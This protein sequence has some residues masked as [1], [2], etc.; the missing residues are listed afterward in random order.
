MISR[1]LCRR[2]YPVLGLLLLL[3]TSTSVSQPSP[4][5][6]ERLRES[7]QPTPEQ[8]RA[9][10]QKLEQELYRVES[11]FDAYDSAVAEVSADIGNRLAERGFYAEALV[12]YRRSLHVLRINEGLDSTRQIPILESIVRTYFKLGEY[13]ETLGYLDRISDLYSKSYNP[14]S[15]ELIPHL[16]ELGNWHFSAY[17]FSNGNRINHLTRAHE[18]YS[19]IADIHF[20][21]KIPYDPQVYSA[22]SSIKFDLALESQANSINNIDLQVSS[23]S[24]ATRRIRNAQ[25]ELAASE[26]SGRTV[27]MRGLGAAQSTSNI[28]DEIVALVQ[29]GDWEHLFGNNMASEEHY[30]TAY[31]LSKELSPDSELYTLFDA[32]KRLPEF[33]ISQ[34]VDAPERGNITS[35]QIATN[36]SKWGEA[37]NTRVVRREG[38][39]RNVV[40]ERAALLRASGATYRPQ[41]V[42]GEQVRTENFNQIISILI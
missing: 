41:I 19:T 39:D 24:E 27:L 14:L 42:D 13:D 36:V 29:L 10:L 34:H 23:T 7:V 4:E 18:A 38:Q 37:L 16:T 3:A 26:S 12:A 8:A 21:E 25:R 28:E 5:A 35:V 1:N 31:H 33:H 30:L 20:F 15:R 9:D 40:A 17:Q 32:P 2:S 11:E 6:V 22:L